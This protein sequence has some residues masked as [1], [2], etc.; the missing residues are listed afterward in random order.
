[1]CKGHCMRK[2]E[3]CVWWKADAKEP[4]HLVYKLGMPTFSSKMGNFTFW[5]YQNSRAGVPWEFPSLWLERDSLF[6][7]I[8]ALAKLSSV[9]I[10]WLLGENAE[11]SNNNT[12]GGRVGFV[13]PCGMEDLLLYENNLTPSPL[14][15]AGISLQIRLFG[16]SWRILRWFV[17]CC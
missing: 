15:V 8:I 12:W 1:M 4:K 9:L 7:I 10:L 2:E 11:K 5:D 3:E 6:F 17:N 13:T 16:R 14:W